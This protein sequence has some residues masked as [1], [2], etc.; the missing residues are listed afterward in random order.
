MLGREGA[1]T[2][3]PADRFVATTERKIPIAGI[4]S[5]DSAS[6]E[7]VRHYTDTSDNPGWTT[8]TD[9]TSSDGDG[10]S[11][12]WY[13]S[14][15]GGDLG[16]I[17]TS[18]SDT[19]N[20][21]IALVD[22]LGAVATTF[23]IPNTN[24]TQITSIG[25]YDEYG[26]TLKQGPNTGPLNY[27]WQGIKERATNTLT[28]LIYMGARLYNPTTGHFTSPD[29]I[30]G[31]NT[32]PYTYPQNPINSD[33]LDGQVNWKK[34]ASRVGTVAA[35]GSLIPGP[36]G[37]I[38][39]GVGVAACLVAKNLA[40]AAGAALG[41]IPG[42]KIAGKIVQKSGIA[43]KLVSAQANSRLVGVNSRLMGKYSRFSKVKSPKGHRI[44]WSTAPPIR[45]QKGKTATW[46]AGA[47]GS[48]LHY[49]SH[50]SARRW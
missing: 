29:P 10:D 45:G 44:G 50:Q 46:R 35:F 31:G 6:L 22:T 13:G 33:D 27:G 18:T 12:T 38:A 30:N 37:M 5:A 17:T 2:Y 48:H 42:A 1:C 43:R 21:V 14:S 39:T 23:T 15:I 49:F 24:P 4:T 8:T 36:I 11:T 16:I 3:D 41:F 40:C 25:E 19:T 26:N 28:G 34:V 20:A 32:T 47:P 9:T 7:A